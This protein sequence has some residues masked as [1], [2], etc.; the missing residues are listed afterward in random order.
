MD[1]NQRT[2][3]LILAAVCVLLLAGGIPMAAAGF[4]HGGNPDNDG[5]LIGGTVIA[6]IGAFG[7]IVLAW[8]A[9]KRA[10][11]SDPRLKYIEP[12]RALEEG[13][14]TEERFN[15]IRKK[16]IAALA[17][18]VPLALALTVFRFSTISAVFAACLILG[19]AGAL[20]MMNGG[21]G[22]VLALSILFGVVLGLLTACTSGMD[23]GKRYSYYVNG[24]KVGE[25]SGAVG[26][27]LS[28]LLGGALFVCALTMGYAYLITLICV[29]LTRK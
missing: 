3:M 2:T 12:G 11:E 14:I 19:A 4:G 10:R 16:E 18:T 20:K 17:V 5:L 27:F 13:L 28:T 8:Q 22:S 7:L 29:L 25:G 6:T 21:R 23:R 24:V 1:K 9:L 26:D 15:A